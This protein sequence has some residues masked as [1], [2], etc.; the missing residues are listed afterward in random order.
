MSRILLALLPCTVVL[1]AVPLVMSAAGW[2]LLRL[3][4]RHMITSDSPAN[5]WLLAGLAFLGACVGS[6]LLASFRN[7]FSIQEL[8]FAGLLIICMLSWVIALMFPAGSYVLFWP[9]L[10][11]S[12]GLLVLEL[13]ARAK[14]APALSAAGLV[15]TTITVLLF[16]PIAYLLYIFLTFQLISIAAVGLLLGLFFVACIPLLNIAVPRGQ[17]RPAAVLLLICTIASLVAGAEQSHYSAQYPRRDTIAYT[18]NAD[19]HS[20]AWIS[21]DRSLDSWTSQFITNRQ[22]QPQPMPNYLAGFQ[23]PVLSGPAPLL[24]LPPPIAEIKSSE[25]LGNLRRVRMHVRSPRNAGRIYLDFGKE[26]QPIS[27]KIAGREVVPIQNS[28]GLTI[29]L[30]GPFPDGADLELA[31]KAQ[32]GVAFW[33]MDRSYGLSEA[34]TRIR[35]QDFM[36]GEGSDETMVCR[37]YSL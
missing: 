4:A 10:A 37:K 26:I 5:S 7:R 21:Y 1:V 3:L 33:I 23:R 20:A 12:L 29:S 17:W 35:P 34:Q 2:L 22:Q 6:L 32:P 25:S 28:R 9:V 27:I 14:S 13:T 24:E 19:D 36:A 11:M 15:G 8:S 16:A 31:F 30:V 18:L